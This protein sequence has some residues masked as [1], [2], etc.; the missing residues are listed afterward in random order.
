M[1]Q[2]R[3]L[4]TKK[5]GSF[6]FTFPPKKNR[7]KNKDCLTL[8]DLPS[9]A[10]IEDYGFTVEGLLESGELVPIGD[11]EKFTWYGDRQKFYAQFLKGK[12]QAG[13]KEISSV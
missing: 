4:N 2:D 3:I 11:V 6:L 5:D 1:K 9:G 10:C 8:L 12:R 13:Q 7:K